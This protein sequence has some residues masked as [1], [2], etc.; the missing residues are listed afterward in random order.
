M[1]SKW[2]RDLLWILVL[3]VIGL[4]LMACAVFYGWQSA[5]S[6]ALELCGDSFLFNPISRC[7]SLGLRFYASSVGAIVSIC[8]SV[9][10]ILRR[11]IVKSG[12][13][14]PN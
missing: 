5:I 9:F 2:V 6:P 8:L 7:R 11:V 10:L 13:Q 12:F 3:L 14:E 4:Y 1:K